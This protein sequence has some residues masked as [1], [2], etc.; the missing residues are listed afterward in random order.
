MK[1]KLLLS[2]AV[3]PAFLASGAV[4]QVINFHDV[5]NFATVTPAANFN[6]GDYYCELFAGQGAYSDPGNNIWNGFANGDT[7]YTTTYV[8]SGAPGPGT[9]PV[10]AGNPGN[11]YAAYN[12][13]SGWVSSD[14][15]DLFTFTGS[16]T[17]FG[18]SDSSGQW[19]PVTL[20]V[21]GYAEDDYISPTLVPNGAP[22]FLFSSAALNNGAYPSES[23]VLQN[24][25]PGTYGLYLYG[26]SP[27]NNGGTAFSLNSGNAHNGI[28]ATLNSGVT[29]APAQTF[30][31]GQ[32]FVIFENVTPD[33]S[34]NITI[35]AS[36]NPLNGIGNSD[37][38]GQTFVNGFQLIFNP[39]PTA[40]GSTAAQNVY[41]GGTAS[42]S[43]SPAFAAS[44]TFRWQSIIGGVTNSLSDG[45][46]ISGSGTT[47]LTITGVSS[48]N[49]GSYQC[50]ITS[51]SAHGTSPAAPL[52]ILTSLATGPL[53]AGDPTSAIGNVLQPGDIINDFSNNIDVVG[54]LYNSVPP[55]FN[56]TY[57]N[58]EDNTLL[59]YVNLG[60]TGDAAPFV[61]PV[62]IVV[63]PNNGATIVT[64]LRLFTAN[65]HPEDDPADY[66][67]EGSNDLTN[68]TTIAGGLLTLP[69][70]RNV[71]SG[72]INI[73]NQV[74]QEIDFANT[75]A[76]ST[77]RLTFTNVNDNDTAS[78]G[79][80]IAELQLLGSFPVVKP[81]IAIQPPSNEILLA[82]S[83]FTATLVAGGPGPLTYQWYYS[84][85]TQIAN[86]TN[87][88]LTLA[89]AQA[90]NS[91]GYY[92]QVSNPQGPTNSLTL[93]LTVITPTP[94]ETA[95]L[96]DGPIC[97][98]PL[99]ETSGTIAFDYLG[100]ADNGTYES[101]SVLGQPGVPNPPFL[102]FP[103]PDYDVFISGTNAGSWVLTPFGTLEGSNGLTI[104]NVTFTC[105]INPTGTINGSA[106]IIFDRG[107]AT[108]GLDISPNGTATA[109]MLG[110]VWN[111]NNG[112]TYNY[113]SN[114]LPPENQWSFAAL[115]ISPTQAVFYLCNANGK[116]SA[117]NP[118]PHF[119]GLLDGAW[120]IGNDADGDPG[121]SFNGS[122]AAVA[123]FPSVLSMAQV[124]ALYDYGAAGNTNVAP[125]VNVPST[126]ITVNANGSGSI[127]ASV[128]DGPPPFTYQWYY[129]VS[130]TTN[131]IIGATES[132]LTLTNIQTDQ[133]FD[134][135]FV[136]VAN[137]YGSST[138]SF[139]TLNILSGAPTLVA[140]V[141][142]LL[143]DVPV[144]LP[145][146]FSV[147]V[148][149][150]EPFYYQWSTGST[151]IAGATNSSYSFDAVAGTTNYSV[152]IGNSVASIS[153]STA[154][155]VGLSG[156]P[157]VVGF[158]DGQ[159]WTL[160][161]GAGWPGSPINPD[162]T[163][164]VLT[165]TDGT[166]SEACSAFYD[167]PQFIGGFITSFIYTSGGN[168]AADGT[169]F[170]LQD[171]TNAASGVGVDA[172][173]AGGGDLGYYGISNSF[174]FE[175]NLYAGSSGGSGIQI[176]T[177]G[178][179]PDSA[180]PSPPYAKPGS[181]TLESG[182]PIHVLIY[183][184]QNV[185]TLSL[186]DET[187]GNK[188]ITNYVADIPTLVGSSS[189]FVGFTSGD[190]GANSIQT[191]SDF[192]Y[193]STTSPILSLAR[194]TAGSLI[195]SWPV[196][197]STLFKLQA[198]TDLNGPWSKV[199]EAP[200]IVD[201]ENQVTLTPG[202][203]TAF[204]R[205]SFQ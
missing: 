4:G 93:N 188:F 173:G 24:V 56:M 35:T 125:T 192:V 89:N 59:Q 63:T 77:Y 102:G 99:N 54:E 198:S 156:P 117:T 193:S 141:S 29:G 113:A 127:V 199:S 131:K 64:A 180:A 179:T 126:P 86:A 203:S 36:P 128:V 116:M 81:N 167:T 122:I 17:N 189:A 85:S 30:V 169:T 14:G 195:I 39:P 61:G 9:W 106:G 80:Q 33:S 162:I 11:P 151:P 204:Y 84:P 107:G 152:L 194:G 171:S 149:G 41:A 168:R 46:A 191:V 163:N 138:S 182:D 47:N 142:P 45:G 100:G 153:S 201:S 147:T 197:V 202:T 42:F 38:P 5:N 118:I 164:N 103:S 20:A 112:D 6:V 160:N 150:T 200:V 73:T 52:T 178:S 72:P 2:S 137:A 40:L 172:V 78:N 158:G 43:F 90:A 154:V 124:N 139:A 88:T 184:N 94:Y 121:R 196:S 21:E 1:R 143:A 91:G 32:N 48:A 129:S 87:A 66:L 60:A 136:V 13:G 75:T 65:S 104:P 12:R 144:G 185:A 49:V 25:P 16:S 110:Y 157:P 69:T 145:I 105:W 44:P 132:T 186:V 53:Q 37:L 34:S 115:T 120:R 97:Y 55:P 165:L 26:A 83:T 57:T 101:N 140:D 79:V 96:A 27:N 166:N 28:A 114:L 15:P 92:C 119:N 22:V 82:G 10:Q 8:Y 134:N 68:F 190:G 95:V 31:E 135:Y 183:Y 205:L 133:N 177:S 130:G 123:V 74:L 98:Y 18:D 19:S 51:G 67:L 176:G 187:L 146:T 62:G 23:F 174:A 155:V 50:V 3:I 111:N 58:V 161:Q 70:A 71:A 175:L 148:T 76:Y 109:G 108:G 170:C 181:V 159:N 7:G